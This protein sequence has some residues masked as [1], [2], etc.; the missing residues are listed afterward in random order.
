MHVKQKGRQTYLSFT[1]Q[2]GGDVLR[3]YLMQVYKSRLENRY[4][5]AGA[6][7]VGTQRL[8]AQIHVVAGEAWIK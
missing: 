5:K 4:R 7:F 3:C 8:V 1:T 6:V 2:R